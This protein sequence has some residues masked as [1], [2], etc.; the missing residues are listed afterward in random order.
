M[1][2]HPGAAGVLKDVRSYQPV[3][4]ATGR[5]PETHAHKREISPTE[6][7]LS[8]LSAEERKH[9]LRGEPI[10]RSAASHRVVQR[11]PR[12]SSHDGIVTAETDGIGHARR[13]ERVVGT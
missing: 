7:Q 2:S 1:D 12:R 11:N 5:V 6:P 10:L 8:S 13:S 4:A 9:T 3:V